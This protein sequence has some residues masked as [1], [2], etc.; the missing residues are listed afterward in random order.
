MLKSIIEN[1][2]IRI[3]FLNRQPACIE[4]VFPHD[5]RNILQFICHQIGFIAGVFGRH[6]Q[7][8]SITHDAADLFGLTF[9]PAADNRHLIS[10]IFYNLGNI[11]R[12]GCLSGAANSDVPNR[13]YGTGE[14][15]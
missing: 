8:L 1:N 9:I 6:Q 4:P 15:F 12:H 14:S 3:K 7:Y 13:N 2:N 10:Q 11:N 5:H